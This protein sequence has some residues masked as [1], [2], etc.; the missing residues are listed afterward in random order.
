MEQNARP[1]CTTKAPHLRSLVETLRAQVPECRSKKGLAFPIVGMLALIAQATFSGVRR[2]PQDLAD[3]AATLSQGQLRAL[4]FRCDKHTGRVRCP[5]V[6]PFRDVLIGVDATALERALLAW[7]EQLLGASRQYHR[8]EFR[9]QAA[10]VSNRF[11]T[12]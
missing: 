5:G 12:A 3:Y 6:T 1:R 2:G 4:G 9:L 11:Q 8:L 7:Q 10:S